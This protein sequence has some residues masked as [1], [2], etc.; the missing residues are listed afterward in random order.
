MLTPVVRCFFFIF[1]IAANCL[2]LFM[3]IRLICAPIKFTYLLTYLLVIG[4]LSTLCSVPTPPHIRDVYSPDS[5]DSGIVADHSMTS[6][7]YRHVTNAEPET[8]ES[9]DE[10]S[11][12][13]QVGF[14]KAV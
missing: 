2:S 13:Q 3:H 6:R 8:A 9:G 1:R 7:R 14:A 5:N 4:I 11:R 12:Q 10:K